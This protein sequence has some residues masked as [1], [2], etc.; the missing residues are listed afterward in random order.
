MKTHNMIIKLCFLFCLLGGI[1]ACEKDNGAEPGF[2][3][4]HIE[5]T[6]R[7]SEM[8]SHSNAFGVNLYVALAS[9]TAGNMMISPLSASAVLTMLLNG[10]DAETYSQIRQMLGYSDNLDLDGINEAY[11]SLVGQ[12]LVVDPKVALTLSN[13]VF[14]RN[15]FEVKKSFLEA[16]NKD[17][18]A[19]IEALNFADP[20]AVEVINGWAS[21]KTGGR[22]SQVLEEIDPE[23]VMFL[24]NALYFKGDW[25]Y[26][27]DKNKTTDEDFFL[28]N[29]TVISVPSMKGNKKTRVYDGHGYSAIE[30]PY[31]QS[32]FTMV[33]VVPDHG[34]DQFG[35][36]LS[37]ESWMQLTSGL[38]KESV[39]SETVVQMPRFSFDFEAEL[40]DQLEALGM[41][42]AFDEKLAD[43]SGISD[44]DIFV[45]MVKQNTFIEVGEEGT[46]AAAVTTVGV[47]VTSVGPEP[48]PGYFI[49]DR[50]FVFAI[51]ERTTNALLFIGKVE[52]P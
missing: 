8:I 46:E 30:L 19:S 5:L 47:G 3:P 45:S 49:V 37:P 15:D 28:D 32:N 11:R 48:G 29:G 31:G 10:A 12:L 21:A 9:E 25:T 24:L 23:M 16:M 7:G 36:G 35:N 33:V 52:T 34:L 18:D 43:L 39:F 50:P 51:R 42:D 22:I 14:Y 13:A 2:M 40:N 6:S 27:F 20:S 26:Q 44:W 41:I 4:K 38:D 17:F 1:T